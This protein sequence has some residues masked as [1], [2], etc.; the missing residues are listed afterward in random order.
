MLKTMLKLQSKMVEVKEL[1]SKKINNNDGFTTMEWILII[2]VVA[3]LIVVMKP[4]LS[5][6]WTKAAGLFDTIISDKI[7]AVK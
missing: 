4:L 1:V 7:N 3:C 5:A 2:I 6:T